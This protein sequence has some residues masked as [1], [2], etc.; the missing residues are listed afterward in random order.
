MS[1]LKN[2]LKFTFTNCSPSFAIV[3]SYLAENWKHIILYIVA[4]CDQ[5]GCMVFKHILVASQKCELWICID[6]ETPDTQDGRNW[7]A[8]LQYS[9]LFC[10]CYY[11]LHR[12]GLVMSF[13]YITCQLCRWLYLWLAT[14]L[15]RDR[16]V[17][18][19]IKLGACTGRGICDNECDEGKFAELCMM[20]FILRSLL[21]WEV[22]P[23]LGDWRASGMFRC[24]RI[25]ILV[26]HWSIVDVL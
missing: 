17:L 3:F 15:P 22:R 9:S 5:I 8:S 21:C 20:G 25:P 6:G 1:L 7:G 16:D 2:L 24:C 13:V 11:F 10:T 23:T 26:V 18:Y 14:D 19:F 12:S 4:N